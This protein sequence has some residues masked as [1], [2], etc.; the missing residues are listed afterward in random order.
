MNHTPMT[1]NAIITTTHT[2]RHT[3]KDRQ[4]HAVWAHNWHTHLVPCIG[5]AHLHKYCT[6]KSTSTVTVTYCMFTHTNTH[7]HTSLSTW[8][9]VCSLSCFVPAVKTALGEWTCAHSQTNTLVHQRSKKP[10][11]RIQQE[12]KWSDEAPTPFEAAETEQKKKWLY[13]LTF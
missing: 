9:V 12:S 7:T 10:H 13:A 4:P 1:I 2:T 5:S 3:C 11:S 8:C 6:V